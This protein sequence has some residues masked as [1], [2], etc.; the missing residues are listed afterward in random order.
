PSTNLIITPEPYPHGESTLACVLDMPSM[1]L[2]ITPE[3]YPH[4]ESTLACV[5]DM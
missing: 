4:G 5:L 3:P 2:I 1:D